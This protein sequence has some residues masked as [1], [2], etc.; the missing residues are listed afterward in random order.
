MR[1]WILPFVVLYLVGALAV[2]V[3]GESVPATAKRIFNHLNMNG[4]SLYNV[5]KMYF[6]DDANNNTMEVGAPA[7]LPSDDLKF[8]FP[9]TAGESGQALLTDGAG[10]TY[11]GASGDDSLLI[12]AKTDTVDTAQCKDGYWWTPAGRKGIAADADFVV[13]DDA[14][15]EVPDDDELLTDGGGTINNYMFLDTELD[16]VVVF[17]KNLATDPEQDDYGLSGE[18]RPA[19]RYVPLGYVPVNDSGEVQPPSQYPRLFYSDVSGAT[20]VEEWNS[21][22]DD[23]DAD[24]NGYVAK[25]DVDATYTHNLSVEPSNLI[26]KS[27]VIKSGA[28][29]PQPQPCA[30][31]LDQFPDGG[32]SN[33]QLHTDVGSLD[34]G[35]KIKYVLFNLT[36]GRIAYNTSWSTCEDAQDADNDCFISNSERSFATDQSFS[37]NKSLDKPTCSVW[38]LTSAGLEPKSAASALFDFTLSSFKLR[39]A[40]TENLTAGT[41]SYYVKCSSATS[42][43]IF[44]DNPTYRKATFTDNVT[45]QAEVQINGNLNFNGIP[46]ESTIIDDVPVGVVGHAEHADFES[47]VGHTVTSDDF[48]LKYYTEAL[49]CWNFSEA[50]GE[51]STIAEQCS[52]NSRD[53]TVAGGGDIADGVDVEGTVDKA[54]VFDGSDYL[55]SSHGGFYIAGSFNIC[56]HVFQSDWST[57]G[58]NQGIVTRYN[59]TT[60]G[61]IFKMLATEELYWQ[62]REGNVTTSVNRVDISRLSSGYHHL[63]VVRYSGVK[64]ELYVDSV[65]LSVNYDSSDG[66]GDGTTLI[67][68]GYTG[69]TELLTGS[70][71]EVVIQSGVISWDQAQIDRFYY[72]SAETSLH[73]G[74]HVWTVDSEP[75]TL[76]SEV[77]AY[78][79]F[80]STNM[81][82]NV[83]G[84]AALDLTTPSG[85]PTNCDGITGSDY[86]AEFVASTTD[87]YLAGTTTS[88][89]DDGPAAPAIDLFVAPNDGQPGA[90]QYLFG[91]QNDS[92]GTPDDMGG[93]ILT[94]GVIR[95]GSHAQAG[96]S[97]NMDSSFAFEDGPNQFTYVVITWDTINGK[98][99]FVN[100]V[101]SAHYPTQNTVMLPGTADDFNIG[102]Y[103]GGSNYLDGKISLFRVRNKILSQE[104]VWVGY[105]YGAAHVLGS[106]GVTRALNGYEKMKSGLVTK[107]RGE[108]YEWATDSSYYFLDLSAFDATSK[109]T[110][111]STK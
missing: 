33:T 59:G 75:G 102:R 39:T 81:L 80:L 44:P 54:V 12:V 13:D 86:C 71:D 107:F 19:G 24:A 78:Y 94:S 62:T 108:D 93:A 31:F 38:Q 16:K 99:I 23:G 68:G 53:L 32:I 7:A 41:D 84:T 8:I 17:A 85:V 30:T 101:L 105:A 45:F 57:M 58:T 89:L 73:G 65:L 18:S 64:S 37:Y 83:E 51:S 56:T 15:F 106:E 20:A 48:Y 100:G 52:G 25:A 98:R 40:W 34:A 76:T 14:S 49:W 60:D 109:I 91:K 74:G 72:A 87:Y 69:G 3:G 104:D 4:V 67:V 27:W 79:P 22:M 6:Y 5:G 95:F 96:S 92:D 47:G 61:Y 11:Y 9:A 63:C 2:L 43:V 36:S 82:D 88:L 111:I 28:T 70:I 26:C 97:N 77:L 29:D 110:I 66:L 35:D 10:N 55:T 90:Q 21:G 103:W 42:G 46:Y 1:K 50:G